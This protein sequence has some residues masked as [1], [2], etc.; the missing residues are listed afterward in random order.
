MNTIDEVKNKLQ[1]WKKY[2]QY[3]KLKSGLKNTS[4]THENQWYTKQYKMG[5]FYEQES[6]RG[7]TNI[8][9]DKITKYLVLVKCT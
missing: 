4:K 3:L 7:N 9:Y 6:L 2:L 8:L 5:S 1:E